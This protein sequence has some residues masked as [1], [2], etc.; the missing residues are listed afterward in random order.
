[1]Y[2]AIVETH[3]AEWQLWF[4]MSMSMSNGGN[5]ISAASTFTAGIFSIFSS[6][7]VLT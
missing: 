7:I 6:K 5:I 1:M 3:K 4:D 2:G